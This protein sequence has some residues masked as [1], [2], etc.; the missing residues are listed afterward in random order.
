[1]NR[2]D[3]ITATGAIGAAVL[4]SKTFAQDN[5]QQ[6]EA[7]VH[8]FGRVITL[9]QERAKSPDKSEQY[10]LG[11][12]FSDLTYDQYRGI[13]V[14]REA[15]PIHAANANRQCRPDLLPPGF[16]SQER[17]RMPSF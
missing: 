4:S 6:A 9:A 1:M 11:G 17:V 10:K 3:F 2:R 16:F 8:S 5:P 13:R 12:I 7:D 15:E 14:R